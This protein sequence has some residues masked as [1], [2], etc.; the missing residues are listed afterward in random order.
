MFRYKVMAPAGAGADQTWAVFDEDDQRSATT[1]LQTEMD[2]RP[3]AASAM[4]L[5]HNGG[6]AELASSWDYVT[7]RRR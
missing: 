1:R 4:L 6:P 5:R 3:G 2:D 7:T